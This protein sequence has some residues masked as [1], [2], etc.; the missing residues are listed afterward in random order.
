MPP[1]AGKPGNVASL[2][3][4]VV[5]LAGPKLRAASS[6]L[7]PLAEATMMG[8]LRAGVGFQP[9]GSGGQFSEE[10]A[11]SQCC[12]PLL[13]PAWR[14]STVHPFLW[15]L[16]LSTRWGRSP[17]VGLMGGATWRKS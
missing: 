16:D 3:F 1:R 11:W 4:P 10:P 2:G 15:R 5:F 13:G 12:S 7:P 6:G 8:R 17:G 14:P 9:L